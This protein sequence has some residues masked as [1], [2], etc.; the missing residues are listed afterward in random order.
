M[1]DRKSFLSD[2]LFETVRW[3]QNNLGLD[4]YVNPVKNGSL[5]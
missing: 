2:T 5:S 4:V 1:C 3:N